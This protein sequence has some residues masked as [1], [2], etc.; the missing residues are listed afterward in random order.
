MRIVCVRHVPFEGPGWIEDWAAERGHD[1]V[2]VDA[3]TECFPDPANVEFLVVL[4]GPMG[5]GD[6]DANP[7]MVPERELMLACVARRKPVLGICLGAQM[8]AA[9]LGGSVRRGEQPEIGWYPVRLSATA[10]GSDVFTGWP[11]Q[12]VTGH[13]HGD[14]FVLP[15]GVG[16]AAA[17]E[18]TPNQAFVAEG[19]LVVGLQFHLEWTPDDLRTLVEC[20]GE[21]LSVG[22]AWVTSPEGLLAE[23]G[24]FDT[25]RTLLFRLLD[26]MEALS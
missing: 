5:A 15:P 26:R 22:G 1:L 24:H 13:W 21:D 20:S 6:V 7:W 23:A 9:A 17:S 12:F 19:G 3:I 8:L 25:G 2:L 18:V 14:T 10:A 16:S 4:G 11:S